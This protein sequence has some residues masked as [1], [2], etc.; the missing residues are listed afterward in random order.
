MNQPSTHLERIP[1][2]HACAGIALSATDLLPLRRHKSARG[3]AAVMQPVFEL[4]LSALVLLVSPVSAAL[5]TEVQ[6][7]SGASNHSL[8]DNDNFSPDNEWLVYDTRTDAGGIRMGRSIEKVHL[9]SKQVVTIYRAPDPTQSGPGIAAASYH[10]TQNQM[11]FIHGLLNHSESRPYAQWRR[12]G[13]LVDESHPGS[14]MIIDARDVEAPF[15]AGALRGGTHRHEFSGDGKWIGFTYNDSLMAEKGPQYNLRTIGV[16]K[17]GSPVTI[18]GKEDGANFSGAGM[19]ALVVRVTPDPAP[20]SDEISRAAF[21][22]WIGTAGYTTADGRRQRARAFLGTVRDLSGHGVAELFVVDIP[23]DLSV[24]GNHGPLEGTADFMPMPPRGAVQ[25]R[26][27]HTEG[28][29]FPGFSGN[30]RSSAD[31]STLACLAKD[32]D[33]VDQVMLASPLDGTIRQLTSFDSPVQSDVR[34]HPNGRHVC[35]VQA[36]ALVVA[37]VE[38]G[39]FRRVTQAGSTSPFALV[40][41]RNGNAIAFNRRVEDEPS[42]KFFAQVFVVHVQPNDLP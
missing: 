6:L 40:W 1:L 7:T 27:T 30:V 10:P 4:V 18:Q 22:S 14:T 39:A 11:L 29:K 15:T 12:F 5:P 38:G 41:S 37:N 25:R 24:P 23:E 31:G 28:S 13:M 19:S 32:Q 42:G 17:L 16:T 8:D 9:Q 33:G 26:L 21:D 2:V 20:G 36:N 34:W 35:F 3:T